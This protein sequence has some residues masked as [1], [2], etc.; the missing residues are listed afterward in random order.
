MWVRVW[1]RVVTLGLVAVHVLVLLKTVTM[2]GRMGAASVDLPTMVLSSGPMLN[3]KFQ[4]RDIGSGT[5]VSSVSEEASAGTSCL[6][7]FLG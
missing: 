5:D 3:G 4:G 1:V 6:G 2:Y 7:D